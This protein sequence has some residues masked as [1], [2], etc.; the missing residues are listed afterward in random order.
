M[1]VSLLTME[2][3]SLGDPHQ[4]DQTVTSTGYRGQMTDGAWILGEDEGE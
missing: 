1:R 4:F 2:T 3:A